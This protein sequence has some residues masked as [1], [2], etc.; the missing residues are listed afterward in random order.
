MTGAWARDLCLDLDAVRV[1]GASAV[2]TLVTSAELR[3]LKVET[4]GGEVTARGMRWFH[5]PIEDVSTPTTEWERDW[6]SANSALHAVLD[7][8]GR[9]LVHC[10][11]GLGRAG[12]VA[13]RLLI[14]RGMKPDA[15]IAAVRAVRRGAVETSAQEMY[16]HALSCRSLG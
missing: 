16:L 13:G 8:G 6:L 3:D 2:V 4:M 7:I 12:L 14:E 9:V 5:L 10:K 11:G 15:A 1:W